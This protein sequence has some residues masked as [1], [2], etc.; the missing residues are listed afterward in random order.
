MKL[1]RWADIKNR[2][3]TPSRVASSDARVA[4][5]A[6]AIRLDS[7]RKAAGLTQQELGRR[8]TFSQSQLSKLERSGNVEIA[9][10]VRYVSAAGGA[11]EIS[12]LLNGERLVLLAAKPKDALSLKKHGARVPTKRARR[13]Q[14]RH[15]QA[16]T[17]SSLAGPG[18]GAK[19][20][21]PTG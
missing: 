3:M 4:R 16:L 10:L 2:K 17:V 5:A 7:V 11:L 9:T 18:A 8:A 13:S 6:L 14:G 15:T 12:A 19:A 20:S 21:R 1:H